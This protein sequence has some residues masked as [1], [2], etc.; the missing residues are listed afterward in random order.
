[1]VIIHLQNASDI[2]LYGFTLEEVQGEITRQTD[3]DG[4]VRYYNDDGDLIAA[5]RKNAIAACVKQEST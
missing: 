3:F 4:F 5:I 1:M 2:T